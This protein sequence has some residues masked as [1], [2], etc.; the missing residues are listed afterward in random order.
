M[1]AEAGEEPVDPVGEEVPVEDEDD[2]GADMEHDHL[3]ALRVGG[4]LPGVQEEAH[5]PLPQARGEGTSSWGSGDIQ[6]CSNYYTLFTRD[7][8]FW[9]TGQ[10]IKL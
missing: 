3:P 1:R 5:P 2:G 6:G 4:L 7:C 10:I 9:L 8:C